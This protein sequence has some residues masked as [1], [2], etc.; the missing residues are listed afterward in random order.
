MTP[1]LIALALVV[2]L[3]VVLIGLS[4]AYFN[5]DVGPEANASPRDDLPPLST[6]TQRLRRA[7]SN[8]TENFGPFIAAVVIVTLSGQA[9]TFTA[10]CGF[11]YVAARALYIPAYL[12]GW[13]PWRSLI[14]TLGLAATLAMIIAAFV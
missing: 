2:L 8:H 7:L 12:Y 10:I 9:S 14:Y 5:R 4:Q 6:A 11:V 1:E 13:A 3:H